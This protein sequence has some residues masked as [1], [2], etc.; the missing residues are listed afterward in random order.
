MAASV[1]S[2]DPFADR[3]AYPRVSVALPAFLQSNGERYQVHLLDVSAGGAKLNCA[4]SLSVGTAVKLD[5][6][7]LACSAVVRWQNGEFVGVCFDNELDVREVSALAERSKA[8]EGRMKTR[9]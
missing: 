1:P 7:T 5:C 4:A 3:R 6:G 8:L 9:E 2:P